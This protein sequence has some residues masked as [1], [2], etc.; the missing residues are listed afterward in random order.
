MKHFFGNIRNYNNPGKSPDEKNRKNIL[1]SSPDKVEFYEKKI[2]TYKKSDLW[3][4]GVIIYKLFT[5]KFPYEGNSTQEVLNN[6]NLVATLT[7]VVSTPNIKYIITSLYL[8]NIFIR[9]LDS[10]LSM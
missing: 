7:M 5:R 8:L 1:N 9:P 10:L 6:I 4:L 2:Y 3:S